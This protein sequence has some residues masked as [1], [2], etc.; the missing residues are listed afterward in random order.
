LSEGDND[1]RMAT[2]VRRAIR[3]LE[4]VDLDRGTVELALTY[5]REIDAAE[6]V[7]ASLTKALRELADLDVDLHDRLLQ[8][9]VKVERTA[10]LAS[11]GPKLL[12]ALE[13]LELSPRSRAALVKGGARG[14]GPS[15]LD[16]LRARRAARIGD[17]STVDAGAT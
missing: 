5:A 7:H 8:L 13:A 15:P 17:A 6:L 10:I 9:A 12:A 4:A 3:E 11:L 16:D 14:H 2:A 1:V